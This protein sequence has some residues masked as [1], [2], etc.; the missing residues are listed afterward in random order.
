MEEVFNTKERERERER[1]NPE[2]GLQKVVLWQRDKISC[3]GG[4]K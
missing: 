4:L 1:E 3:Y 2:E